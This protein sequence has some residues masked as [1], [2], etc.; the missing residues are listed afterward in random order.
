MIDLPKLS[1]EKQ[2]MSVS[3]DVQRILEHTLDIAPDTLLTA[4]Q[5][6]EELQL[7]FKTNDMV[8]SI[9]VNSCVASK[10]TVRHFWTST[11]R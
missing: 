8:L 10:Q 2:H 5:V 3:L 1:H 9:A 7:H 6:L 4:N 11:Y